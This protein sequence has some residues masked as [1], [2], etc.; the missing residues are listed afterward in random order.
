ME[1]SDRIPRSIG[2]KPVGNGHFHISQRVGLLMQS[3]QQQMDRGLLV[4]TGDYDGYFGQHGRNYD[5]RTIMI[6][7][8]LDFWKIIF[9]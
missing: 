1:Q 4:I 2:G 9:A 6:M 3:R 7:R 8:Y 5:V